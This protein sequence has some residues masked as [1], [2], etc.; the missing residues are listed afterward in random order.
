MPLHWVSAGLSTAV[1]CLAGCSEEPSSSST[2]PV[3][4]EASEP[5]YSWAWDDMDAFGAVLD[6]K[7]KADAEVTAQEFIHSGGDP[8]Q[9]FWNQRLY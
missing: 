1:L 8:E 2:E 6:D 9:R 4:Q 5:D 3:A 7:Q